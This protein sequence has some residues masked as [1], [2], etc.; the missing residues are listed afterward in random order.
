MNLRAH[1]K[2]NSNILN[3]TKKLDKSIVGRTYSQALINIACE[4]CRSVDPIAQQ[5]FK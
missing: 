2:D 5:Q 1:L 3:D 4:Y